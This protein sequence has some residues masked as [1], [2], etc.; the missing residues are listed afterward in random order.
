[1]KR[2]EAPGLQNGGGP[3]KRSTGQVVLVL[4]AIALICL[5]GSLLIPYTRIGTLGILVNDA[6]Q[7]K[8]AMRSVGVICGTMGAVW[9]VRLLRCPYCKKGFLM[10]WWKAGEHHFCSSCGR[11]IA[12]EDDRPA[13]KS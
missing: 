8:S 5:P 10:P 4:L 9:W 7:I 12:F 1:M 2:R 3:P 13:S 11:Q 6:Y